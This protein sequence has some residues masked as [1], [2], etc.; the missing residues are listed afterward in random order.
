M[1]A[2]GGVRPG[3]GRPRLEAT[4][5]REALVEIAE[6][7]AKELAVVLMDKALT[8]DI[9]AIKEMIDRGIGKALQPID[10]STNGK[11]MLIPVPIMAAY[12]LPS[13]DGHQKGH[14][15]AEANPGSP[16]G[17]VGVEDDIDSL[18]PDQPGAV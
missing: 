7:R 1:G 8:G 6:E 4:K 15:D 12:A 10:H 5:L 18:V 13:D 14:G 9:P 17:N 2:N 3:A 11:D 16:G